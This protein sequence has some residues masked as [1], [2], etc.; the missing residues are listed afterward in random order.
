MALGKIF[1][2]LFGGGKSEGAGESGGAAPV[3]KAVEY[4]GFIIQATPLSQ[5]GQ[6]LTAGTISKAGPD[7]SLREH[8]FIRADTHTDKDAAA[9]MAV[10]KGKRIVDEQGERMF[11]EE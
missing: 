7:G 2:G 10:T 6:W 3:G 4:E 1:G 9:E 5:G 8:R 11:K